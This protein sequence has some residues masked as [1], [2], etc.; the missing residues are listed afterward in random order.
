MLFRSNKRAEIGY[1]MLPQFQ[2]K[3]LTKEVVAEVVNFCFTKLNLH[4]LE[5]VVV[6]ENIP[7]IKLLE[8]LGFV[9]EGLFKEK[10]FSKGKYCDLAYYSKINPKH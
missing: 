8:R 10:E 5:A 1:E 9:R 7:S 4:S 6:P 2:G 3:G